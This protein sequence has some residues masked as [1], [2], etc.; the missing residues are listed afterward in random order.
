MT[1]SP[2]LAPEQSMNAPAGPTS[3]QTTPFLFMAASTPVVLGGAGAAGMARGGFG[4]PV[5]KPAPVPAAAI[6]TAPPAAVILLCLRH[7]AGC[8]PDVAVGRPVGARV[9]FSGIV[10]P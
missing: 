9:P 5:A 10:S 8:C 7:Q 6:R 2:L 1:V 3:W 4:V